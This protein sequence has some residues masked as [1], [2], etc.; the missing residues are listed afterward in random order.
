MKDSKENTKIL[1][2]RYRADKSEAVSSK[3]SHKKFGFDGILDSSKMV[4]EKRVFKID[5]LQPVLS[6]YQDNL[7]KIFTYYCQFGE[8]LN[9]SSMGSS[10][11]IKLLKDAEVI[12]GKKEPMSPDFSDYS[13]A[14]E[15]TKNKVF[16]VV[17][18]DI[19]F[20]KYTGL[21]NIK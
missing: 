2:L 5:H 6:K 4:E 20:K 19:I 17:D 11:F 10:K 1:D 12:G 15:L 21:N 8:P 14:K 16:T 3:H 18:A 9:S 7:V 13:S